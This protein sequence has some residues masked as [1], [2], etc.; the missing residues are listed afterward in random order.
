MPAEI[1]Q[2]ATIRA[3]AVIAQLLEDRPE[4]RDVKN[5]QVQ[6]LI[7]FLEIEEDSQE[8]LPQFEGNSRSL[9]SLWRNVVKEGDSQPPLLTVAPEPEHLVSSKAAKRAN[10]SPTKAALKEQVVEPLESY[11][12]V[13]Q[14]AE[15][16]ANQLQLAPASDLAASSTGERALAASRA[17]AEQF[18][19]VQYH[20]Q[21]LE[22][23]NRS[24]EEL[25]EALAQARQRQTD[26]THA[27]T[28]SLEELARLMA[29]SLGPRANEFGK[30]FSRVVNTVG[31]NPGSNLTGKQR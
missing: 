10:S 28:S 6:E 24:V 4:F 5:K 16:E 25:S 11:T 23:T 7:P 30:L 21:M 15:Q 31:S 2:H 18:A 1:D 22:Q 20:E 17:L 14:V 3:R 19:I 13:S 29:T 8:W 12:I 27:Y 9:A 26:A